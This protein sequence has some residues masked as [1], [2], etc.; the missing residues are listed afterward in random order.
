MPHI[1][2][3]KSTQKD[4]RA[5]IRHVQEAAGSAASSAR[6][7]EI[8]AEKA[9]ARSYR[10][11]KIKSF[12]LDC[13]G[14]RIKKIKETGI[15]DIRTIIENMCSTIEMNVIV[16]EVSEKIE[17]FD[18]SNEKKINST[19][20]SL[21]KIIERAYMLYM[22][23]FLVRDEAQKLMRNGYST[24]DIISVL[25]LE[26]KGP[27]EEKGKEL[28]RAVRA[29]VRPLFDAPEKEQRIDK[30]REETRTIM[31]NVAGDIEYKQ[32]EEG[33]KTII[34]INPNPVGEDSDPDAS[35]R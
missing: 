9:R 18:N 13:I 28:R 14:E 19:G 26:K 16:S 10:D 27:F 11:L 22:V 1:P 17:S 35:D 20:I 29:V 2:K 31:K 7:R 34:I 4:L 15:T 30:L 12:L 32:A 25:N 24:A 33:Q 6:N 21:T 5:L 3:S 23:E 8:E